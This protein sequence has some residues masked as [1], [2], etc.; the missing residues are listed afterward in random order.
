M[1]D[2]ST[3]AGFELVKK[4][5]NKANKA[6]HNLKLIQQRN[7]GVSSAR[8]TGITHADG[9]VV[10]FLD[11][12]DTWEPHFLAEI[13]Q[14]MGSFPEAGAYGTGY[15]FLQADSVY[16]DPKIRF[17]Y[18]C[19]KP[20]ILDDYFEIGSRGD[21]P[22]T[23]SSFAIKR[24]VLNEIGCFPLHEAMGED[25]DLFCRAAM[26]TQIAYSPSVLS[27][28]HQ[29]AENRACVSNIPDEECTFSRRLL[30]HVHREKPS[31]ELRESILSYTAAHLLHLVSLN[32]RSGRYDVANELLEDK[33]CKYHYTR[34]VW[35]KLRC[36]LLALKA[37]PSKLKSRNLESV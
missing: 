4:C 24:S 33:R 23:M 26:H 12:D 32:V 37:A 10:V 29:D 21:L 35:W 31:K 20:R 6:A 18:P 8:N 17:K 11:A 15:Q 1:D 3:D 36:T 30:A 16:V 19:R 22:F 28:Y 34:Y 25:Q 14:L 27:F 5:F 2:G 9:D 13:K 7:A